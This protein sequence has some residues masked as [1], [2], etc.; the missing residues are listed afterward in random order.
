V[1]RRMRTWSGGC[2]LALRTEM[3]IALG[4]PPKCLR[5]CYANFSYFPSLSLLSILTMET[6][7]GDWFIW[8]FERG[9]GP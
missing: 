9:P 4:E 1:V 5:A 2:W 6:T 8:R 3:H 7:N